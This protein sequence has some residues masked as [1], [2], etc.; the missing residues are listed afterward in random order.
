MSTETN[1][2]K[3]K[4]QEKKA[5]KVPV[6]EQEDSGSNLN[7]SD[8][9][10]GIV[11]KQKKLES[12]AV[13]G[14]F[15]ILANLAAIGALSFAYYDSKNF[16]VPP[17]LIPTDADGSYFESAPLD[18]ALHN[19]KEMKQWYVDTVG[20]IFS[21]TYRTMES[22]SDSVS[23]YFSQEGLME[24]D[25]FIT[26][27]KFATKVRKNYGIVEP[28]IDEN[29]DVQEGMVLG[30]MG[31]QMKMKIALMI[32]ING[33]PMRAGVYEISSIVYRENENI[34]PDGIVIKNITLRGVK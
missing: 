12:R 22:H 2:S 16:E 21:Y 31:W 25:K 29:V 15:Q 34:A 7:G 23:H 26:S 3:E 11:D 5:A 13:S 20:D 24:F 10:Q 4:Q 9:Y 14:V 28:I 32:Y 6:Q 17:Q 18:K 30:R 33:K 8:I 27:S 1:K 19:T